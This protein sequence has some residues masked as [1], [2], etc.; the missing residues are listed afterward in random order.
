MRIPIGVIVSVWILTAVV[1]AIALFK[2]H[3][4]SDFAAV[5]LAYLWFGLFVSLGFCFVLKGIRGIEA[6]PHCPSLP[7]VLTTSLAISAT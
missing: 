4:H 1:M 5:L 2:Y 7:L 3:A 6:M